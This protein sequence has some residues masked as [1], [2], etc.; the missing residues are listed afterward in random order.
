MPTL[1]QELVLI[2][3]GWL[4]VG[5]SVRWT[6]WWEHTPAFPGPKLV[7][8][9]P[10]GQDAEIRTTDPAVM[11]TS[12]VTAGS[13]DAVYKYSVTASNVGPKAAFYELYVQSFN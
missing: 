13:A 3:G 12:I 6:F 8:A 4:D 1:Q 2:G 11:F 10:I 7:T 9:L 5:Q